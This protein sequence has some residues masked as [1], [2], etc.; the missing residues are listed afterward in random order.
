MIPEISENPNRVGIPYALDAEGHLVAA[1][2]AK[3]HTPYECPYC[4]CPVFHRKNHKGTHS[5]VRY[6]GNHH[7]NDICKKIEETGK[8][9]SLAVKPPE[10]LIGYLCQRSVERLATPTVTPR[11]TNTSIASSSEMIDE[12]QPIGYTSLNQISKLDFKNLDPN[13]PISNGY[14]LQ[15]YI[16]SYYWAKSIF[17]GQS[18]YALNDRILHLGLASYHQ[19]HQILVFV[20]HFS[21]NCSVRFAMSVPDRSV[22]NSIFR[23][24]Y[25]KEMNPVS[26]KS[27]FKRKVKQVLIAGINWTYVSKS[28]CQNYVCAADKKYCTNCYGLYMTTAVTPRQ[29]FPMP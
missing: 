13:A 15:D 21:S 20:M 5:F 12:L 28:Q 7:L 24:L 8:Y 17:S 26:N 9:H 2:D 1:C 25:E 23:K 11:K 27:F 14:I 3:E 19:E 29:V 10:S 16:V 22:F 18:T 6:S 4:H